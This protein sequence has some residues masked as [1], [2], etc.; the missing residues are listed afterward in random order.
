MTTRRWGE[1]QTERRVVR[2]WFAACKELL[3]GA[4]GGFCHFVV[5]ETQGDGTGRLPAVN[6]GLKWE[7]QI[8]ERA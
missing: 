7:L 2:G 1:R 6:D 8:R 3:A 4:V 5:G